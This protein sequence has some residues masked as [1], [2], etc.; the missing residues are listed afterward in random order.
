MALLF[1]LFLFL[2]GTIIGSF[3]N[4][5]IYRTTHGDSPANG[6]SRCTKCKKVIAWYDNI[7]LLSFLMLKGKCRKCKKPISWQYPIVEFTTGL[8]F[9]W[10]YLVGFAF[11]Q[12]TQQPHVYIQPLYWLFIG[13]MLLIIFVVDMRYFIIPDFA[14]FMV[15][16][17]ALVYR[18]YLVATNVMR[19]QDAF[20]SVLMGIALCAFLGALWYFTKGKGMGFGDVKYSL[21][22]GV[23]LGWPRGLVGMFTAFAIGA[24]VGVAL[25]MLK[26]KKLKQAI[27]FGPFL[28]I[29]TL[30]ALMW[31]MPLWEWYWGMM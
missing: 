1:A 11:F 4:V 3:L 5:V 27:P 21:S 19:W 24:L 23:L 22:M 16:A 28:V 9:V 18:L 31:G 30:V 10:W 20:S 2:F 26:R 17:G 25:L 13:V 7:P 14:T 8:L 29:G 15:G 12:L 6:R